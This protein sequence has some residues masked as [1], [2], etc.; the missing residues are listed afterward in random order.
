MKVLLSDIDKTFYFSGPGDRIS[1]QDLETIKE[2]QEA[3]NLFGVCTGRSMSGMQKIL[4]N[5]GLHFDFMILSSGAIIIDEKGE[6]LK[7]KV[8]SNELVLAILNSISSY[9]YD[10]SLTKD[11][12]FYYKN[13]G[14]DKI[15]ANAKRLNGLEDITEIFYHS[16]ALQFSSEEELLKVAIYLRQH[17]DIEVNQNELSLDISPKGCDK[18]TGIQELKEFLNLEEAQVYAIGDSFNDLPMF[19]AVHH[20]FTFFRSPQE[21][22]EQANQ[23]VETLADCIHILLKMT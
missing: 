1:N 11:N 15:S 7:N 20:S 16:M 3:G 10:F 23:L 6:F 4:N 19:N 8:L 17:F 12:M 13:T 18:G 21:V 5:Y 9:T 2:F 22:Q 14:E